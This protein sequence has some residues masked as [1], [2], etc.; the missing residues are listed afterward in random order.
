[1]IKNHCEDHLESFLD[2]NKYN[3]KQNGKSEP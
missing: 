2:R 3:K 1:M